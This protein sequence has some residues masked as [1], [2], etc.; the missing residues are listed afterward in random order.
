MKLIITLIILSFFI[1][2]F[3]Q[4]KK[5]YL[6]LGPIGYLKNN[7]TL[8]GGCIG[9]GSIKGTSGLGF[10]VEVLT[11]KDNGIFIPI[12]FDA[13]VY[14]KKTG[15]RP[16]A[17]FQPGFIIRNKTI[18][19]SNIQSKN[20][21]GI[22]LAGGVGFISMASKVGMTFQLKYSMVSTKTTIAK[23]NPYN[24]VSQSTNNPGFLCL[25]FGIAI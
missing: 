5:S 13:R 1:E 14:F 12:Y 16:F 21:G 3:G 25:F 11:Q 18:T 6:Q 2:T 23:T 22:Y 20:T 4:N 8:I 15:S 10:G 19:I 7:N 9:S 17:L 24:K